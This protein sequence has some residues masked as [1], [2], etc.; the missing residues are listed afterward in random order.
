V[1]TEIVR[2]AT[3]SAAFVLA[4][5][6]PLARSIVGPAG[7]ESARNELRT[8]AP[9]P[10]LRLQL[11]ALDT[12][13]REIEAW[14]ADHFGFRAS[15][16]RWHN[17]AKWFVLR[18]S[19]TDRLVQGKDDWMFVTGDRALEVYRGAAPFTDEELEGWRLSLEGRRDWLARRGAR[20]VFALGPSKSAIYPEYLP[21]RVRAA[22]P[23]RMDQLC[24]YLAA[25]SD[26]EIADLRPALRARKVEDRPGDYLYYPLGTHW[27]DRGSFAAYEALARHMGARPLAAAEFELRHTQDPGDSWSSRMYMEDLL[28][29][30]SY[31]LVPR[32]PVP[33]EQSDVPGAPP[34]T[35]RF[36]QPDATLP[37]AVLYHD[38]FAT[39]VRE[40]LA[41]HFS[42]LTC[43]WRYDFD[44]G[45]IEEERPDVVVQLVVERSLVFMRPTFAMAELQGL[46][47]EEFAASTPLFAAD[48]ARNEPPVVLTGKGALRPGAAGL[49][50][51][52]HPGDYLTLPPAP[53]TGAAG[54]LLRLRLSASAD[55]SLTLARGT[56]PRQLAKR[57][58]LGR[59][60]LTAGSNELHLKLL[61][62][63]PGERLFL[64]FSP[65]V[66]RCVLEGLELRSAGGG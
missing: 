56:D 43:Y 33:W 61:R 34:R 57:T 27:T 39:E 1:R 45:R 54:Q 25:H 41:W 52:P 47:A 49:A 3:L 50:I 44:Q 19:P 62:L 21:D 17:A 63:D 30:T 2:D 42:R 38:S 16:L 9:K 29:Q 48:L 12:Y 46:L 7:G 14:Y 37:T 64:G 20:F 32:E 6:L 22:G 23:T 15:L 8:P 59:F 5:G 65:S 24:A 55:G 10:E 60:P 40:L 31:E 58:F 66:E 36:T 53:P 13:P 51:E 35:L 26:L 11:A 4:S 18:T 28:P